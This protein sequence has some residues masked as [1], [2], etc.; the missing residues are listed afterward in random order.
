MINSMNYL[1]LFSPIYKYGDYYISQIRKKL[2]EYYIRYE[3]APR[4]CDVVDEI[5]NDPTIPGIV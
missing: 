5:E 4:V 3:R 1:P 2:L